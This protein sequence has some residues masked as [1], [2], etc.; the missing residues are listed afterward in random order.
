MSQAVED[1]KL[2]Q[3]SYHAS[4]EEKDEARSRSTSSST[5]AQKPDRRSTTASPTRS[6]GHPH[7][8]HLS[9]SP[10]TSTRSASDSLLVEV[11]MRNFESASELFRARNDLTQITQAPDAFLNQLRSEISALA[12]PGRTDNLFA[13]VART[14]TGV[15]SL[16]AVGSSGGNTTSFAIAETLVGP[17]T[18]SVSM[19]TPSADGSFLEGGVLID[20]NVHL[21]GGGGTDAGGSNDSFFSSAAGMV[22]MIVLVTLFTGFLGLFCAVVN[23]TRCLR[24][25]RAAKRWM[26]RGGSIATVGHEDASGQYAASGHHPQRYN[27][28]QHLR[29]SADNLS[30]IEKLTQ[31]LK[32]S[33]VAVDPMFA[34]EALAG[35]RNR[36]LSPMADAY[37]RGL[38]ENDTR[39]A[40]V[41]FER[42]HLDHLQQQ[43]HSTYDVGENTTTRTSSK[44]KNTRMK[45]QIP[46]DTD[47]SREIAAAQAEMNAAVHARISGRNT[48]VK[49]ASAAMR[50]TPP[51][52]T[53]VRGGKLNNELWEMETRVERLLQQANR[54]PIGSRRL[55]EIPPEPGAMPEPH[56]GIVFPPEPGQLVEEPGLTSKIRTIN[57]KSTAQEDRTSSPSKRATRTGGGP[58]SHVVEDPNKNREST[59][60]GINPDHVVQ[61]HYTVNTAAQG[62]P[63]EGEVQLEQHQSSSN[64]S[65]KTTGSLGTKFLPKRSLA[66]QENAFFNFP[67]A[68]TPENAPPL[69]RTGVAQSAALWEGRHRRGTADFFP[70][71]FREVNPGLNATI[72]G[73]DKSKS[74]VENGGETLDNGSGGGQFRVEDEDED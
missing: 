6:S 43:G 56:R 69:E 34:P 39:E 10:S 15:S 45:I 54:T 57:T 73:E 58:E 9:V 33:S 2:H 35:G 29:H 13:Q 72:L 4:L 46:E 60:I 44:S 50:S 49:N 28:Q 70:Q 23:R 63:P 26:N 51:T 3:R 12:L 41:A 22:V 30:V 36:R 18:G 42:H 65:S 38:A 14:I 64:S 48:P 19:L 32:G 66:E 37:L 52:P 5:T 67:R 47:E 8:R 25:L 71:E 11:E 68:Q 24:L 20:G 40:E 16:P 62:A 53:S 31:R 27:F 59:S 17:L 61:Q 21:N 55:D 7:H 74:E 1:R